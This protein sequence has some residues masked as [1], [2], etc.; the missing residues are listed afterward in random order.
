MDRLA[1]K[2]CGCSNIKHKLAAFII[3]GGTIRATGYNKRSFHGS[4]HA[5]IDA[6][7]KMRFQKGGSQ[8]CDLYVYRFYA[9]GG[10]ALAKPCVPCMKKIINAGIKRVFYS[11]YDNKMRMIN[12][13][14]VDLNSYTYGVI[15]ISKSS[16]T[17]G[18]GILGEG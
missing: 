9:D 1:H 8:G 11:D 2:L 4:T 5:E 16:A 12:I 6:I 15:D 18:E 17:L 10:Y 7:R 3:K 14:G 13:N